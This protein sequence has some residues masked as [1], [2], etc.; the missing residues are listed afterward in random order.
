MIIPPWVKGQLLSLPS[1]RK[2]LSSARSSEN[3]A[4]FL[5]LP[6]WNDNQPTKLTSWTTWLATRNIWIHLQKAV[7][8]RKKRS[9]NG[10]TCNIVQ[11]VLM[12][13]T[14]DLTDLVVGIDLLTRAGAN[15]CEV[16]ECGMMWHKSLHFVLHLSVLVK[17][18]CQ[19]VL[20][21]LHQLS[22]EK[23]P[24]PNRLYWQHTFAGAFA[25]LSRPQF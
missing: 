3:A 21:D 12:Q 7:E 14:G 18:F 16:W 5:S 22:V 17:C 10:S 13:F 20:L 9:F 25:S 11:P 2:K 4:S 23:K 19:G 6:I 24:S 8:E 1:T 15:K